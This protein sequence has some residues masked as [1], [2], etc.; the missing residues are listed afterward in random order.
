[1]SRTGRTSCVFS[2]TSPS[3][4]DPRTSSPT[5][6]P[7][8]C[9]PSRRTGEEPTVVWNMELDSSADLR[10]ELQPAKHVTVTWAR[11]MPENIMYCFSAR[12]R[13]TSWAQGFNEGFKPQLL[14]R[15]HCTEHKTEGSFIDFVS[16]NG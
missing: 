11:R 6:P 2:T 15:M 10:D 3:C 7:D 5:D 12:I 14:L 9:P 4:S 13:Y 16:V 1:M 8:G